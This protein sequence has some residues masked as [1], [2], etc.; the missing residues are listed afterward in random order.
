MLQLTRLDQP[1]AQRCSN[2]YGSVA[3]NFDLLT[4]PQVDHSIK[5]YERV[6]SRWQ[7]CASARG[8]SKK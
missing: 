5:K 3:S 2:A 6:V 8:A 1:L 7:A 4:A